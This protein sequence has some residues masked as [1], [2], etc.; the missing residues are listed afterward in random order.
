M[1]QK[2][3]PLVLY[4]FLLK[5]KGCVCALSD[6]SFYPISMVMSLISDYLYAY[7]GSFLWS[8]HSKNVSN[9]LS[10][11]D[12]DV[13]TSPQSWWL[14]VS[15]EIK[16]QS[17]VFSMPQLSMQQSEIGCMSNSLVGPKDRIKDLVDP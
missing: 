3:M 8:D 1:Y 16:Y 2:S 17:F 14:E 15:P 7:Q 13:C 10:D 11:V 6:C 9:Q 4:H 12:F 5:A